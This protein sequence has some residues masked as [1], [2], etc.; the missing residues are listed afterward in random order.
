MARANSSFRELRISR[1]AKRTWVRFA[2]EVVRH[3]FAA[4]FA[5]ATAASTTSTV[6]KS[7]R[8]TSSPVA[9]LKTG[10]VCAAGWV[11]NFPSMKCEMRS[12]YIPVFLELVTGVVLIDCAK[13]FIKDRKALVEF[14]FRDIAWR[15]DMHTIEVSE[16]H[17]SALLTFGDKFIHRWA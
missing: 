4:A 9:G 3:S 17:K 8:A 6:A 7:T 10:P 5:A 12:I 1:N 14:C 13:C 11:Q 15:N 16:W 2:S